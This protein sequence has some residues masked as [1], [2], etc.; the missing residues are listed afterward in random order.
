MLPLFGYTFACAIGRSS[1]RGGDEDRRERRLGA[2]TLRQRRDRSAHRTPVV[3]P[4]PATACSRRSRSARASTAALPRKTSFSS[5][6]KPRCR[7]RRNATRAASD[8]SPSKSPMRASRRRKRA[9]PRMRRRGSSRRLRFIIW[10]A[11]T[12]ASFHSDRA[13][14]ASRCCGR[15]RSRARSK[16]FAP[17]ARTGT[18][19]LNTNGSMPRALERCI[20]AGLG[21]VRVSLNSFRP[22]VYAAYYRPEGYGLEDVLESVRLA[23]ARGLR[24]SLNLSD[25]PRRDRRRRRGGCDGSVLA[26]RA[27]RDGADAHAQHRSRAILRNRRPA[28]RPDR[29]APRDRAHT[30]VRAVGNFTHTH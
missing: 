20:D 19:N 7:F 3:R 25:A 14:R 24:V 29:D 6:A 30:R 5:A 2:A 23:L 22:R 4:S 17:A 15:S 16:R 21:A 12:T 10:S 18:I 27:G 9:S 8:A 13:A 26:R 28:A 1:A 11:S